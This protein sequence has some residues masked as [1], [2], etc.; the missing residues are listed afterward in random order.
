MCFYIFVFDISKNWVRLSGKLLVHR[1]YLLLIYVGPIYILVIGRN[2]YDPSNRKA[3]VVFILCSLLNL[4]T[5]YTNILQEK[6]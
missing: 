6:L 1:A 5:I 3:I 4:E 2:K